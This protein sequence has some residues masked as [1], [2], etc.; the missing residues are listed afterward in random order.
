M[1]HL[2]T[3]EE[4]KYFKA[5][6]KSKIKGDPYYDPTGYG[7]YK[8]SDPNIKDPEEPF[9][10]RNK[11]AYIKGKRDEKEKI[12]SAKFSKWYDERSEKDL[13]EANEK[14]GHIL[15]GTPYVIKSVFP[16]DYERSKSY[17]IYHK[18][19]R[20]GNHYSFVIRENYWDPEKEAELII[21][22]TTYN[23]Y[24]NETEGERVRLKMPS[25]KDAFIWIAKNY[26]NPLNK[27]SIDS[28]YASDIPAFDNYKF[29]R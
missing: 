23:Q 11:P 27:K 9:F 4:Y 5:R 24:D 29:K 21:D 14:Y 7:G 6:K 19:S 26:K 16:A 18:N 20:S 15:D 25:T 1:N 28:K 13:E 22:D 2:K 8:S 17:N 10:N 12:A 3:N